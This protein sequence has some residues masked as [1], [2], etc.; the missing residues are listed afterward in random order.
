[1]TLTYY[2][3]IDGVN[4]GSAVVGHEGAFAISGYSF[5]VSALVSAL[6]GVKTTFSPLTVDLTAGSGLTALLGDVA[7]G[8]VIKSIELQGVTSTGQT[9]YDLKL[10]NVVITRYHDSNSGLDGLSFDYSEGAVSLTTTPINPDGSLG[11]PATVSWNVAQNVAGAT[12]PSPVPVGN[13]LTPGNTVTLDR[14]VGEQAAL[15]L[16]IGNTDIGL[17]AATAVPFTTSLDSEDSGTV[18]FTDGNSKTVPIN[19]TG[20]QTSYIADLSSLTGGTIT[21]SLAVKTDPAGNTFTPVPGN[22]VTL[23]PGPSITD[24]TTA[25]EKVARRHHPHRHRIA[26][27]AWRHADPDTDERLRRWDGDAQWWRDK[28][29]AGDCQRYCGVLVSDQGSA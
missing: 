16:T 15:K 17:A 29:H 26:G 20:G 11:T 27:T 28:L 10:S 13:S 14:D 9:V 4:G 1:M 7:S 18:T 2:L 19:V 12:V 22:P 24:A 6:S 5:D 23:D 3:T 21:S 25:G 8:K